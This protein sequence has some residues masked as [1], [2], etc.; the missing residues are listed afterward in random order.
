MLNYER[1]VASKNLDLKPSGNRGEWRGSCPFHVSDSSSKNNFA[2]NVNTGFWVC[3]SPMCALRGS[4]PLFYKLLEGIT[5]WAEVRAKLDKSLPIKNWSELLEF[6]T[7]R[8]D[9]VA[10]VKYQELPPDAFQ[11]PISEANFPEYLSVTRRYTSKIIELG[12]D[13]RLCFGGDYRNRILFPFYDINGRLLTFTA[14]LMDDRSHS[15]RYRFPTDASTNQFLYGIH[16]LATATKVDAIWLSEG[17]FDILRL[18]SFGEYALGLSKGEI[19][20]RQL[21]DVK[22]LVEIYSCWVLVCL[23]RG[24]YSQTLKIWS[25]LKSLGVRNSAAID[26]GDVAKDPDLLTKSQMEA[27]KR[28][29]LGEQNG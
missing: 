11:E 14:R 25:E 19:S 27:L 8:K 6:E 15:D 9:R 12:F 29:A 23:D 24:A 4:F 28:D 16:R 5:S 22:R 1:Y 7:Q 3:R 2:I 17:Q 18:S 20:N 10:E 26:I 13:L 21:L